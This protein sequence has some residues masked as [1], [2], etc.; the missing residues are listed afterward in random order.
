LSSERQSESYFS[1][2]KNGSKSDDINKPPSYGKPGV[3]QSKASL[4]RRRAQDADLKTWSFDAQREREEGIGGA[5][6]ELDSAPG[7]DEDEDNL[8]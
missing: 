6:V 2:D 5:R 8:F 4:G 3:V 7:E 1:S